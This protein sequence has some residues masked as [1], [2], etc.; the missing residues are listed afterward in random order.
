MNSKPGVFVGVEVS[1]GSGVWGVF[2]VLGV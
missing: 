2:G 1:A